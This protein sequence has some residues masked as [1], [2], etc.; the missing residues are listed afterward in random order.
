MRDGAGKRGAGGD[1]RKDTGRVGVTR[2]I[3]VDDAAAVAGLVRRNREFLAPW[4]PVREESYFT[5]EGQRDRIVSMLDWERHGIV[6]PHV[7]LDEDG[8]VQGR[9]TLTNIVRGPFQ[10]CVVGYWLGEVATGRGLAT[11]AV[12]ELKQIA[13]GRLGLHRIEAGTLTHNRSSQRVLE[14]N[15]FERFG[16]APNYLQID[17]RWQ[18]H[19]LFQVVSE[20]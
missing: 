5:V 16:L 12:G 3:S 18:D 10:S 14:R 1:G 17:G 2:L 4:E 8:A 6:L 9:I 15:G 7:I 13:F 20:P 19:V 11:R